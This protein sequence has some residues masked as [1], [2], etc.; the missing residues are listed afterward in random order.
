MPLSQGQIVAGRYRIVTLLGQGGMG[1]VY[2]AW[3]LRLD[4]PV[5]LKELLVEP[6][7]SLVEVAQL[8]EQFQR[9][10]AVLACL[11]HPNLVRVIDYLEEENNSYLVMEFVA[12]HSLS[13]L[14]EQRGALPEDEVLWWAYQLLDALAYCHAQNV[15]H[16]D[17]K[18]GNVIIC[19]DGRAVL[20][21]FGLLKRWDPGNPKT[22]TVIRSMAT[23]EYAPPEQYG[24]LES[25]TDPRSD[26]YSLGATLYHALTGHPPLP[27]VARLA[28]PM[29]FVSPRA[30]NPRISPA[31]DAALMRA[32]QLEKAARFPN[33]AAMMAALGGP[34]RDTASSH[35]PMPT[36]VPSNQPRVVVAAPSPAFGMRKKSTLSWAWIVGATIAGAVLL[37]SLVTGGALGAR[38]LFGD[39]FSQRHVVGS[40]PTSA[41]SSFVATTVASPPTS[42]SFLLPTS[43]PLPPPTSTPLPPPTSTPLPT[44]TPSPTMPPTAACPAVSGPFASI[45]SSRYTRLGCALNAAHSPLM[46]QERFEGGMM[47]WREDTDRIAVLYYDGSWALY[48]DIWNEGE[49]EYSCPDIAPSS[50]PPTPRRGFGKIWCTYSP[51]RSGLGSALEGERGF[52]GGTVQDFEYGTIIRTEVGDTYVMYADGRWE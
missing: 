50:S 34:S 42:V 10:A 51:V 40:L 12:G 33:A 48:Q 38:S 39:S 22:Q 17:V 7:M 27:A 5:A 23:L 26:L 29:A 19:A 47:F 28:D 14:I 2:R 3:D 18:P 32:L 15:L 6:R 24:G 41:T 30:L 46:A 35:L 8:R 49:P 44:A 9:E 20:V 37:F 31:V 21:D 45:W 13:D 52:Y 4:M 36:V 16:R 11:N 1:A 43:T 25:H